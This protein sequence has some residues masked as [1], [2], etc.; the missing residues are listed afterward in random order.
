MEEYMP[1]PRNAPTDSLTIVVNDLL[2]RARKTHGCTSDERLAKELGVSDMA[3]YRWRR[4][5]LDK[6]ARV[7]LPLALC[8]KNVTSPI[9]DVAT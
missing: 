6:S 2:D 5:I 1:R 3:I 4:G 9:V 7:L 8:D